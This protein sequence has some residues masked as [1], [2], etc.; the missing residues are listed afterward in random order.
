MKIPALSTALLLL[1]SGTLLTAQSPKPDYVPKQNDRPSA[2]DGDGPGY[3]T[4]FD[5]RTLEGWAGDPTYWRVEDG[6]IVGEITPAT[7]VRSNTFLI[8]QGG[9]PADFE[10]KLEYRITS[11]GNSGINYR[12]V[13]VPDPVNP[14]NAFAMR[15]YQFD[16]DGRN[17]YTGNNYEEKGRLFL[18]LRG[19]MTR[20]VGQR[21]PVLVAQLGDPA[22]LSEVVTDGWNQVHIIARG[23]TLIHLLNGHVLSV[24]MD[25]DAPHRPARGRI[26]MQVH[27]G[28]P[29]KIEYRNLR[30]RTLR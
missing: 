23:T 24:V 1:A 5:G 4:I 3:V 2:I 9:E 30:L 11:A 8:W 15:G 27:T 20:V 17:R 26:G 25:D 10:L 19:Q 12:S 28:P 14:D 29:M 6:A 18:A 7:L 21:P 13:I 22:L 16:L